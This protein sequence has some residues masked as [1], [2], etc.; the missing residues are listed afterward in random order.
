MALDVTFLKG[1]YQIT[2]LAAITLDG[3][4]KTLLLTWGIVPGETIKHWTWFAT[5]LMEDFSSMK[6]PSII[7]MSD[8]NKGLG[9]A[10]A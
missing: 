2:L 5:Y 6:Q 7:I 8:R 4:N 9:D 10:T 3:N 1:C